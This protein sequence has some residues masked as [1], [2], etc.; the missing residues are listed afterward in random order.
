MSE[1]GIPEIPEKKPEQKPVDQ[2]MGN[3][4]L[5]LAV[6]TSSVSASDAKSVSGRAHR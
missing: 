3:R 6:T 2:F 5:I 1:V 4:L